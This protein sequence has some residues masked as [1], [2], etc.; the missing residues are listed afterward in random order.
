MSGSKTILDSFLFLR[1]TI[2][3]SSRFMC[4]CLQGE[5]ISTNFY[6]YGSTHMNPRRP[7]FLESV[8]LLV[9]VEG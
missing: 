3:G 6:I 1:I 8:S 4:A 5:A 9:A 7:N 2:S